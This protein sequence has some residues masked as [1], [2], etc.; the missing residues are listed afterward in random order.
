MSGGFLSSPHT[1]RHFRKEGY[2]PSS[3]WRGS[4]SAWDS[5]GAEKDI[6]VKARKRAAQILK[7]HRIE[8]PLDPAVDRKM[9]EYIKS[10]AKRS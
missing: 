8:V 9:V 3:F 10:V 1:L 6:V 7:D 2:V 4:R 5:Q